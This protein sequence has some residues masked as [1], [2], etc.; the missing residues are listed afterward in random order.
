MITDVVKRAAYAAGVDIRRARPPGPRRLHLIEREA[1]D[2]VVDVGA[3]RGQYGLRLREAGY[4]GELHSF[5]PLPLAFSVL[6]EVAANDD[7]WHVHQVALGARTGS[8]P[9][10]VSR[11]DDCS[12]ILESSESMRRVVPEAIPTHTTAVTVRRLDEVLPD[13]GDRLL[14]KIDTQGFEHQVLDGATG[15][16]DRVVVMDIEMALSANY[17]GGS[18]IYDLMPRLHQLGFVAFSVEPGFTDARSGQVVDVDVL[19]TRAA[20]AGEQPAGHHLS[21]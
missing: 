10:H 14:L 21:E 7:R 3:N 20:L 2:V 1:V 16:L 11:G 4:T 18:T 15:L 8:V 19:M 17:V 6:A 9:M 5:E 12:S 13:G